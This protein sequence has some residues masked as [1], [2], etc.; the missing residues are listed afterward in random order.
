MRRCAARQLLVSATSFSSMVRHPRFAHPRCLQRA[1]QDMF[2]FDNLFF[3]QFFFNNAFVSADPVVAQCPGGSA[4]A[5]I[6]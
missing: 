6:R 2:F 5:V 3:D 1:D 4:R